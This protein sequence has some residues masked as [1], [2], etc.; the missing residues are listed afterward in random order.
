MGR[1]RNYERGR[2]VKDGIEEVWEG[3]KLEKSC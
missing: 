1:R 2:L 3:K